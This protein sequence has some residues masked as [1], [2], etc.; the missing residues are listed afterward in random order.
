MPDEA[1]VTIT[2]FPARSMGSLMGPYIPVRLRGAP[3]DGSADPRNRLDRATGPFAL[4]A[5]RQVAVEATEASV[6]Q[7]EI[8]ERGSPVPGPREP[9]AEL[10]FAREDRPLHRGDQ[11]IGERRGGIGGV[12]RAP[13][14]RPGKPGPAG[15]IAGLCVG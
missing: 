8:E 6:A 11:E 1:P 5:G 9:P 12:R 13:P 3:S 4:S 2:V 7:Q 14:A 15:Q 10:G